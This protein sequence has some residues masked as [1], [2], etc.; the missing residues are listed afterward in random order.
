VADEARCYRGVHGGRGGQAR[1][2]GT[3]CRVRDGRAVLR[4]FGV[5]GSKSGFRPTVEFFEVEK[6]VWFELNRRLTLL[7]ALRRRAK[8]R[9]LGESAKR[10]REWQGLTVGAWV[11]RSWGVCMPG[12]SRRRN[13]SVA[14][15]VP[16]RRGVTIEGA[17]SVKEGGGAL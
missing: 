8:G 9:P 11:P 1:A 16:V 17:G 5:F 4:V 2:E 6:D 12:P 15:V 10:R 7:D 14:G 13:A 3:A